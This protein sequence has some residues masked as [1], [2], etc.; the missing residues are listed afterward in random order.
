MFHVE[1]LLA[2]SNTCRANGLQLT[3]QQLELF[4]RYAD[5]L[6]EWNAKI[7]LVSRKDE[8]NIWEGHFLH[9]ISPLFGRTVQADVNLLDIGTGGGLPGI[10]LAIVNDGWSVTLMDSIRKKSVATQDIVV[11]LGMKK[12]EVVNGRAEDAEILR[13]RRGKYQMVV[14]R[15]VAPLV[16]L[17]A[18]SRPYLARNTT[19]VGEMLANALPVPSLLAYK[20]GDLED[21]LKELRV[22]VPGTKQSVHEL[23]FHGSAEAGLEGKKLV[24]VQFT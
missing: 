8:D 16:Q 14:A 13:T 23:I 6:M 7:N 22:K 15:G 4:R 19:P 3:T 11:R 24:V 2:F 12:I 20:G 18:W 10:P 17:V 5:L 1:H 21:E 9:S